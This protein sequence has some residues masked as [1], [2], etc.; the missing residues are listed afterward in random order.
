VGDG[1]EKDALMHLAEKLNLTKQ[2]YFAGAV[3]SNEDAYGFLRSS[4]VFVKVNAVFQEGEMWFFDPALHEERGR[5]IK[6]ISSLQ[7]L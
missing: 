5:A 7:F 3:A 6:K 4:K 2:V 1:P